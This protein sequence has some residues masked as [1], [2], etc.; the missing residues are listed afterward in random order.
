MILSIIIPAYNEEKTVIQILEKINNSSSNLFK[1]EVIVI[2]DGSTDQSRKLLENS[3]HLFDKLLINE[4]IKG[5]GFYWLS[6]P[7]GVRAQ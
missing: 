3:N 5:K 2:D 7:G 4:T 1:Y 6:G